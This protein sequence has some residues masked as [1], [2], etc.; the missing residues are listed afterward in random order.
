MLIPI[1][2]VMFSYIQIA[3][4]AMA[5]ADVGIRAKR[6]KILHGEQKALNA[7]KKALLLKKEALLTQLSKFDVTTDTTQLSTP[8]NNKF[9]APIKDQEW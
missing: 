7:S 8:S 2:V 1:L 4:M 6:N 9:T 3:G 5:W